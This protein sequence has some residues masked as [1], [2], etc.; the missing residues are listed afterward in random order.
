[1]GMTI[2]ELI[3]EEQYSVNI[4]KKII[5]NCCAITEDMSLE[6]MELVDERKSNNQG[7][8]NYHNQIIDILRKYQKI[9]NII[10][11][12]ED[13]L[14]D[15]EGVLDAEVLEMISDEVEDGKID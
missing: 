3:E 6:E 7:Y 11:K 15:D 4:H 1:M 12:W 9:K 5:D 10:C 13:G 2:E 8:V 14:F